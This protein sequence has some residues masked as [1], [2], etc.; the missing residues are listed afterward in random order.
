ML[1]TALS[2]V[3]TKY[4]MNDMEAK[5]IKQGKNVSEKYTKAYFTGDF[6][7]LAYELQILEKYM[8]AS[9]FF[10]DRKGVL[11]LG[12]PGIQEKWIGQAISNENAIE[13][14]L[15]GKI[16]TLEGRINGIFEEPVLT[17]GYPLQ[18]GGIAGIF[19]CTS[20]PEIERS[21]HKINQAGFLCLFITMVLGIIVVYILSKKITH[22]LMRMNEV[23][24]I[25][26]GGN[27]EERVEI[28]S[29]DEV[30]QLADSFNHM[31]ESLNQYE[32]VRRD[33]IAN[34]SHDLRSPLT[35]MQGFLNAVLDGTIPPEKQTHYLKIVLEETERLTKLTNGIVE[36]SMAQ[37]SKITLEKSQF[38]I[39]ELIREILLRL[40]AR[41]N[42]NNISIR[43]IFA[44]N[45]TFVF[46]DRDKIDRVFYNLLDNA[47]KFSE[48]S[49]VIEVETT[50]KDKN[51]VFV[52][53]RDYGKG[54]SKEDQKYV[55]DR[56]YKADTSRGKDKNC[57]GLGLSIV[58]EFILAHGENIAVKSEEGK[59][60][61]FIFSLPCSENSHRKK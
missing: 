22:P 8:D 48:K 37:N 41:F 9:I 50:L 28:E 20:I 32:N 2:I 7:D 49:G 11:V 56:F 55:F 47:I 30:G 57:G 10:I 34:V 61:E 23:A 51:K 40:E 6:K 12:S 44:E 16:V 46:A 54:I 38:D 25:I 45:E 27:F 58:R 26:A 1:G 4:Y 24:K 15:E 19:M 14:I 31:A 17:V 21:L 39:N 35:S 13:G 3:F 29:D 52:S 33:F 5:L 42:E 59:S 53:V 18:V 43:V 60:T 36:L